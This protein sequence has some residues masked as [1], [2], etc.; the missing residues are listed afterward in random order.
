M[1][2][3]EYA[4]ITNWPRMASFLPFLSV[5]AWA[6]LEFTIYPWLAS[7]SCSHL[8]LPSLELQARIALFWGRLSYLDPYV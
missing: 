1:I 5:V 7:D 2:Y 3:D 6:S 8:S 4:A